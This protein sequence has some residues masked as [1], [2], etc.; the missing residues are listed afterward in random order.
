MLTESWVGIR[1]LRIVAAMF[2]SMTSLGREGL[3]RRL[4]DILLTVENFKRALEANNRSG[5]VQIHKEFEVQATM[6]FG[7]LFLGVEERADDFLLNAIDRLT[8]SEAA[9]VDELLARGKDPKEISQTDRDNLL[10]ELDEL[11][12]MLKGLVKGLQPGNFKEVA[13]VGRT[14]KRRVSHVPDQM[15]RGSSGL[16]DCTEGESD[17]DLGGQ[18]REWRVHLVE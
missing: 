10:H 5:L 16:I 2:A 1:I 18:S 7:R 8:R 6:L 12:G 17:L 15:H 13:S 9:E 14:P 4:N 11:I 3:V